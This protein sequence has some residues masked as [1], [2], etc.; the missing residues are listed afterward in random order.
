MSAVAIVDTWILTN[1][2]DIPQ[3][4]QD[5]EAVLARFE[6][7]IQAKTNLLLPMAAIV[8]TG[9]HIAHIPDGRVRRQRAEL[10]VA[11]VRQALEGTAPWT[12]LPFPDKATVLSWLDGFPDMAMCEIGIADHSMIELWKQQCARFPERRVFI[13]SVDGHLSGHDRAP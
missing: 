3:R 10:F 8:E 5:R 6:R 7:E 13:W 4:N 2:L 11:Q 1:V 12:P 9:N